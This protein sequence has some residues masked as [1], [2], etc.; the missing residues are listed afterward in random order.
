MEFTKLAASKTPEALVELLNEIASRME[1]Q[2]LPGGIQ[3]TAITAEKL[4]ERFDLEERGAVQ[5]KGKGE[6]RTLLLK[7]RRKWSDVAIKK[8]L[9][10]S[11]D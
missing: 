2:G 8:K 9:I 5:V 7:G 4:K 10:L 6:M 3:C 1:T 11:R